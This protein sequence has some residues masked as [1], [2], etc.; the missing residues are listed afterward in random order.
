[1]SRRQISDSP[2]LSTRAAADYLGVS[3]GWL[4][5]LRSQGAGP[6][7]AKVGAR[8]IYDR[9]DLDAWVFSQRSQGISGINTQRRGRI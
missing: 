8:V 7:Y 2:Y 3:P 9:H 5:A 4:E 1:M 6:V